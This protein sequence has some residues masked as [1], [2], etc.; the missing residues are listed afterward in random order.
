MAAA[1][2][3]PHHILDQAVKE[4]KASK[5]EAS[6]DEVIMVKAGAEEGVDGHGRSGGGGSEG[7]KGEALGEVAA[8]ALV[9]RRERR[10]RESGGAEE[11]WQWRERREGERERG[12]MAAFVATRESLLLQQARYR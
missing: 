3:V 10:E 9:A 4:D 1:V 2:G 11:Q 7:A 5:D 6:E 12:T 8:L